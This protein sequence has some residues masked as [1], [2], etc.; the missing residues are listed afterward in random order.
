M[1]H[2]A[3]QVIQDTYPRVIQS[4]VFQTCRCVNLFASKRIGL[5]A[6][7]L[8]PMFLLS[9]YPLAIIGGKRFE[10]F[11]EESIPVESAPAKKRSNL[12]EIN[13][14]MLVSEPAL[15]VLHA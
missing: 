9:P 12:D 4:P 2:I 7:C 13:I 14:D 1:H 10:A 8:T 15:P 3:K 6:F 11:C 5:P